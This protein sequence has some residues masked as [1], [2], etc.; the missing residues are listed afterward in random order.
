MAAGNVAAQTEQQNEANDRF[1]ANQ[2]RQTGQVYNAAA[3]INQADMQAE[4]ARVNKRRA[5]QGKKPFVYKPNP[6]LSSKLRAA[7][8]SAPVKTPRVQDPM[9]ML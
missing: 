3:P 6:R 9:R 1:K 7:P 5:A 4:Y 8:E 2:E